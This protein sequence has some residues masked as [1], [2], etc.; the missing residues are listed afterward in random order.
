MP[1]YRTK[2][3]CIAIVGAADL[4]I[5]SLLNRQQYADPLGDAER[6]GISSANW[7]LFGLLW[8][9]GAHLAAHM[10]SRPLHPRERILEMGCG[11][12]LASLVGH[13]RGA[14]ITASD[15]HPLAGPFLAANLLLNGLPPLKYRRG[16][17]ALTREWAVEPEAAAVQGQYDLLIGSDVLYDRDASVALASFIGRHAAPAAEVQIV[18]PNRGNQARFS[19]LMAEAGFGLARTRLD[20]P[21]DANGPGYKGGLLTY[22]RQ[23]QAQ[24]A[25]NLDRTG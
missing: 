18:D 14:D 8:P 7:P 12:G 17:W 23:A 3:E 21:Q 11:L 25:P 4:Q 10:A 20:R 9:S 15:N 6:A 2:Q 22:R 24:P 1:G 13:R 16:E 5:R 19:A